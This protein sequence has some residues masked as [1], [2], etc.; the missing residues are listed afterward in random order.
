MLKEI[1]LS[2]SFLIIERINCNAVSTVLKEI[3][4][5]S[6]LISTERGETEKQS[7]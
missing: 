3:K 6:G 2:R 1:K 7:S 4:L 5:K